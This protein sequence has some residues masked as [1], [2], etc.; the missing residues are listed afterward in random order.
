[1]ES[2]GP[3]LLA[4]TKRYLAG[5]VQKAPHSEQRGGAALK[6][7][8]RPEKNE[9]TLRLCRIWSHLRCAARCRGPG[10]PR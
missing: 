4:G 2:V 6:S 5:F 7:A 10:S 3:V 9:M 8:G 1:M